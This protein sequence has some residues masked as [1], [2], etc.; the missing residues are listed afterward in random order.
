[1]C[2]R[3]ILV[4]LPPPPLGASPVAAA[5]GPPHAGRRRRLC[6]RPEAGPRTAAAAY[7]FDHPDAFDK[8]A[9]LQC[10][11]DLK[12]RRPPASPPARPPARQPAAPRLTCSP[13]MLPASAYH[14]RRQPP[15]VVLRLADTCPAPHS[16]A[17][18]PTPPAPPAPP[19]ECRSVEVPTYDFNTHQ[20]SEETRRVEPADVVGT[21]LPAELALPPPGSWRCLAARRWRP[22]VC[23][24]WPR[25]ALVHWLVLAGPQL[26]RLLLPA[27][28]TACCAPGS[29]RVLPLISQ[30]GAA[31]AASAAADHHR[32][33]PGAAH[34]GDT[35]PAQHAHLRGHGRWWGGGGPG[36]A[37]SRWSRR[38][39]APQLPSTCAHKR[40]LLPRPPAGTAAAVRRPRPQQHRR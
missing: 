38:A 22:R 13:C 9:I 36:Q 10:L 21:T 24:P 11:L 8:Q 17:L 26:G 28:P 35:E 15:Y 16:P 25:R 34:R 20:R 3:C 39:A 40:T 6:R 4:P 33:H 23:P 27:A 19:Q 1:M 30:L 5:W 18:P 14:T 12:V 31:A 2:C 7:N 32:G 29:R 37:P